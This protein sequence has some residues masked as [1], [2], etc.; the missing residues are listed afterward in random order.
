MKVIGELSSSSPSSNTAPYIS[1][2]VVVGADSDESPGPS[3]L[4][5]G[6]R[7]SC[8]EGGGSTMDVGEFGIWEV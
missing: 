5:A 4:D 7:R 6:F 1:S 8:N 2:A 3:M